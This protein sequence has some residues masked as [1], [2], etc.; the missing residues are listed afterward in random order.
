M[1]I[2]EILNAVF[3]EDIGWRPASGGIKPVHVANGLVR[4]LQGRYYDA[5]ELN[6]FV[7]WWQAGKVPDER[8]SLEA[9]SR[10]DAE[11]VFRAFAKSPQ[12][13]DRL[14]RYALGLLGADRALFPTADKSSFSLTCGRMVTRDNNDRGLGD[15][16]AMLINGD[17]ESSLA[18]EV[19]RSVTDDRPADPVT[20][21]VWPL[22]PTEGRDYKV[23][24]RLSKVAK[25]RH[26]K[27]SFAA[28]REAATTLATH[29][30]AQ[31]NRLRTLHRAVHFACVT[32][33]VH[34]QALAAGGDLSKRPPALIA[35]GGQR[36]SDVALASERSLDAIYTGF[37]NW[38][39][40]RLAVRMADGTAFPDD[41][42]EIRATSTDGRQVRA[43]LQR[44]GVARKPHGDPTK[45][46][47]DA[48]A[49]TFQ[50]VRREF[51]DQDA[52]RVLA[53]T[54]VS[55]YAREYE[56]GG[57]R[58]F[59]QALGRK[60]GLLYPHFQG[61]AR[62]KRIRPSVPIIDVLVRSCVP[63]REAIPL[64]E[65]LERLWLRFGLILGGRRSDTWDDAEVLDRVG[66]PVDADALM[67]NTEEF[68]DELS[69][70][71]LARR[72]PDGVT[73]VGDGYGG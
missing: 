66:L 54:L 57:P 35:M 67:R 62:E 70:M 45:E 49:A 40:E 2:G 47:T 52:T 41:A 10:D 18:R 33:H 42:P 7:V 8:R 60:V 38:L 31:G 59:L 27:A 29:E 26:N 61:A 37:E 23:S 68:I 48:R 58:R 30:R 51:G 39:G 5:S 13:F 12:Q 17:D 24:S 19:L 56:S 4:A 64:E 15:F 25:Q 20:A 65:F 3:D 21:L 16:G 72:Y 1:H 71:G 43:V 34:A 50:A 6:R 28:I 14:R 46:E 32:T 11:G 44:V 73:F 22:L 69:M 55:C 9:L 36:R 63:A 53:H